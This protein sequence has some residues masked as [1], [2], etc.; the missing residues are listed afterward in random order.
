MTKPF[1]LEAAKAGAKVQTRSGYNVELFVF[2]LT[3]K[4]ILGGVITD[5]EGS[6]EMH[7]WHESGSYHLPVDGALSS[8][9][10]VM[11]VEGEARAEAVGGISLRDYFA[12]AV[13]QGMFADGG[14]PFDFLSLAHE[15]YRMA[16]AM[17]A[18]REK[19]GA[20]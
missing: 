20:A 18:Q 11:A 9:D 2:D 12:A 13:L 5:D 17:L 14:G 6:R 3:G 8:L 15:A 7:T 4:Q 16:D 19:G 1:D 10:L